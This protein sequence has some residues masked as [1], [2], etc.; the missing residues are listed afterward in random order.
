VDI[1]LGVVTTP[2][3]IRMV[4][5]EGENADGPTADID[6]DSTAIEGTPSPSEQLSTAILRI[7]QSAIAGG[8]NLVATG[9]AWGGYA[10]QS[11]LRDSL[12]ARGLDDVLLVS[13]LQAASA[14][15]RSA[16]MALGHTTTAL[17]F[18]EHDTATLAM[19]TM[20]DGSMLTVT[21]RSL[22]F[23]SVVDLLPELVESLQA[24]KPRP[25]SLYVVGSGVDIAE[26]K[27][28]LDTE[29]PL[30]VCAAEDPELA[31]ARGAALA[32]VSAPRFEPST[33]GLAYSQDP[34]ELIL[35]A[36]GPAA[37]GTGPLALPDVPTLQAPAAGGDSADGGAERGAN[38]E[39]GRDADKAETARKGRRPL[40][41]VGS[42]VATIFVLGVVA[43]VMS[44]A[45]SVSPTDHQSANA[46][47]KPILPRTAAPAV[48]AQTTSV[49]AVPA[50]T[51]SVQAGPAQ[52]A[53][54]QRGPAQAAVQGGPAQA[55]P[56]QEGSAQAAPVEAAPVQDQAALVPNQH[57]APQPASKPPAAAVSVPTP[58]KP[59]PAASPVEIEPAAAPVPIDPPQAAAPKAADPP[60]APVAVAPPPAAAPVAVA[61]PPAAAPVVVAPPP[62]AAP[63]AVTPP[64]AAVPVDVTPP[65]AAVKPPVSPTWVFS[66][67]AANPAFG[68]PASPLQITVAPDW[69]PP[70]QIAPA[71]PA[72]Q[73]APWLSIQFPPPQQRQAPSLPQAEPPQQQIPIWP[74]TP[75]S[76]QTPPA[77]E[78]T[79][80]WQQS[81]PV[82]APVPRWPVQQSP[83]TPPAPELTAPWQQSPPVSAPVP[84]WPV[85]PWPLGSEGSG[86]PDRSASGGSRG[87]GEGGSHT[88]LWPYSNP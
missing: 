76:P 72:P 45:V 19:V 86:Y 81:P 79:A 8:H 22:Q 39:L 66:P 88:A 54:V 40:I 24:H 82:S 30:T 69:R 52:A 48:P 33:A 26:V 61:Q 44:V 27:S 28:R 50:Q 31:L 67:P 21:D 14:L 59:T 17:L 78:L 49:Q 29:G 56:V 35:G 42:M 57:S 5:V 34:E 64:P 53:P 73:P 75:Q 51:T 3:T 9:V 87:S 43:I 85:Q 10:G 65:P 62:A 58:I 71:A 46:T 55:A 12:I 32:A 36:G 23:R 11:V 2:T 41:P 47:E 83:Q 60:A 25:Q 63:V 74:Q 1:V 38:S 18:V 7:R 15:A 77:P 20:A 70:V 37:Q 80:P 13:E 68:Q 84:R 16:G 4:L 6:L